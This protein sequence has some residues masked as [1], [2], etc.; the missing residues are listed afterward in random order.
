MSLAQEIQDLQTNVEALKQAIIDKGGTVGDTGLAGCVTAVEELPEGGSS[1]CPVPRT[2]YGAVLVYP[3]VVTQWG[4]SDEGGMGGWNV[5]LVSINQAKLNA[6]E[7]EYPARYEEWMG[8]KT[9]NWHYQELWDDETGESTGEY[10]WVYWW[11]NEETGESGEVALLQDELYEVTGIN[12]HLEDPEEPWGDIQIVQTVVGTGKPYWIENTEEEYEMFGGGS[13]EYTVGGETFLKGQIKGFAFGTE[14]TETVPRFFRNVSSF[15]TVNFDH[16]EKLCSIGSY[17]LSHTSVNSSFDSSYLYE[18][19]KDTDPAWEINIDYCFM[20]DC[21]KLDKPMDFSHATVGSDLLSA[22]TRFNSRVVTP[23][24]ISSYF[25]A[26]CTKFNAPLEFPEGKLIV[27]QDDVL[28]GC[29]AFNQPLELNSVYEIGNSFMGNCPGFEQEIIIPSGIHSIGTN[30]CAWCGGGYTI[31][32]D[33]PASVISAS[34]YSFTYTADQNPDPV[35]VTGTYADQWLSKFPNSDVHPRRNLQAPGLKVSPE[36]VYMRSSTTKQLNLI[37]APKSIAEPG[38]WS[39][40]DPSIATVDQTGL[41]TGVGSGDATITFTSQ[42]GEYSVQTAV[43]SGVGA[44]LIL[45]NGTKVMVGEDELSKLS[46]Q[47][48][49][50]SKT[51][52]GVTVGSSDIE[53]FGLPE[54]TTTIA[55]SFLAYSSVSGIDGEFPES[56][57][58]IG[59]HFL[60]RC[61]SFNQ[62]LDLSHV[63]TIRFDF[64]KGCTSFNQPLNLINVTEL[65]SGFLQNCTSFNSTIYIPKITRIPS[66]FLYGC[67]KFNQPIDLHNITE[68]GQSVLYGCSKFNQY[69]GLSNI[70]RLEDGFLWFCSAFNRPLNLSNVTY[71]GDHV[72]GSCQEFNQS[73]DL[74]NVTHIGE[75]FLAA[76]FKFNQNITIPATVQSIGKTFMYSLN[77]MVGTVTLEVPVSVL[78]MYES[79]NVLSAWLNYGPTYTTGITLAGTYAQ[80]WKDALPDSSTSPYRKLIVAGG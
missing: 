55:Y 25:L 10:A 23:A 8:G 49:N 67:S 64:L 66:S 34:D 13:P 16:A 39:S 19:H 47:N 38:T 61:T 79:K 43:S 36:T 54:G 31:V 50:W 73:L 14:N 68:V 3:D 4:E 29:H 41:V 60:G 28:D 1:D 63:T 78:D 69:L 52:G 9:M 51:I 5:E 46:C 42:S 45:K 76:C 22:C 72:L 12:M 58:E 21:A 70:T 20:N 59:N 77:Q 62:S 17:F 74:S 30:F 27:I 2:Q 65:E 15:T 71:I 18:F 48:Q 40:S 80:E 75:G 33:A 35:C 37:W 44:W 32:A 24:T 56:V 26:N 11:E 6:F 57:T 53:K 7:A